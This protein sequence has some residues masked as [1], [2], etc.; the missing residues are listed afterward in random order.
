[1]SCPRTRHASC[2]NRPAKNRQRTLCPTTRFPVVGKSS[3]VVRRLAA[4]IE[5]QARDS[6]DSD[7]RR[8]NNRVL[9]DG[10]HVSDCNDN[11]LHP[12]GRQLLSRHRRHYPSHAPRQN[13]PP[14]DPYPGCDANRLVVVFLLRRVHAVSLQPPRTGRKNFSI[15]LTHYPIFGSFDNARQKL[16]G[17][18]VSLAGNRQDRGPARIDPSLSNCPAIS[19]TASQFASSSLP[20]R[21]MARVRN[22]GRHARAASSGLH[23]RLVMV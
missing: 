12:A 23:E 21:T 15:K 5:R 20:S 22:R 4:P 17:Y 14:D 16:P 11:I 10:Q 19:A 1:M 7:Q 3:R 6:N 8:E 18:R 2:S 9:P 13:D